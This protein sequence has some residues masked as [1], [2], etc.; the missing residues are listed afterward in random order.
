[1]KTAL[2]VDAGLF[3]N[4][5]GL[6]EAY[7]FARG[8]EVI[9]S[10]GIPARISRPLDW[11]VIADHSDALGLIQDLSAGAP[12]VIQFAQARRWHEGLRAGGQEAVEATL[13]L[14]TNFSQGT[15]DPG[16]LALYAEEAG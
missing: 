3:G 4:R 2:S 16:L 13:D 5:L 12:D 8:E 6:D 1:M 14:I 10:T 9:S 7:R 11:L 15:I